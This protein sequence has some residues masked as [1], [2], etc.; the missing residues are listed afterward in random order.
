MGEM[1]G[2]DVITQA[3]DENWW[4]VLENE[5]TGSCGNSGRRLG[6]DWGGGVSRD[7]MASQER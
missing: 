4:E 1:V 7:R 5:N 2:N 6:Y 3:H